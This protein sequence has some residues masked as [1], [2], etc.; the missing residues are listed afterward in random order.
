MKFLAAV[1]LLVS[2][3]AASGFV[4]QSPHRGMASVRRHSPPRLNMF[5]DVLVS[6]AI[7]STPIQNAPTTTTN[8]PS[9]TISKTETREGIYGS[10]EIEVPEGRP[11]QQYDDAR[12]TFKSKAQTKKNRNK[13]VGI[14]AVLLVGSFII[15]MLQYFWYV[16]DTPGSLFG[17][18]N[19]PPP[20]PPPPKKKGLF[21]R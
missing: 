4:A 8:L 1:V 20:P 10:Y 16:R 3:H 17:P 12:S 2:S 18:K 13:Y 6:A 21:G 5:L 11:A 7:V 15:P 19:E 14:F 9:F